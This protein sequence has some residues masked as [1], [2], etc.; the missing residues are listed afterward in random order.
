[1]ENIYKENNLSLD[2]SSCHWATKAI[3]NAFHLIPPCSS[4]AISLGLVIS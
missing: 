2:E 4:G 1:M 3:I